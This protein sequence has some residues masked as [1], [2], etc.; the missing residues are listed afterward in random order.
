M[1]TGGS[2]GSRSS[3]KVGDATRVFEERALSLH[4]HSLNCSTPQEIWN[5]QHRNVKCI[6][7]YISFISSEEQWQG[8]GCNFIQ[9][10]VFCRSR[11]H[12]RVNTLPC[13]IINFISANFHDNRRTSMIEEIG[14]G[15]LTT[16]NICISILS[17][18]AEECAPVIYYCHPVT[19]KSSFMKS[20]LRL[21]SQ[22]VRLRYHFRDWDY[23]DPRVS[24]DLRL[25]SWIYQ[26]RI[27]SL[28]HYHK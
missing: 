5:K 10:S 20:R 8:T 18:S 26:I 13:S 25:R 12:L 15:R 11:N 1:V 16:C 24:W 17:K 23:W 4:K 28:W 19:D 9:E 22:F 14:I 7:A 27:L 21:N 2:H 3:L 6:G